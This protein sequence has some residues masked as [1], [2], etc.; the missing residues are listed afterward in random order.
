MLKRYGNL[1]AFDEGLVSFAPTQT[2]VVSILDIR[3][4]ST[5]LY[6]S[7]SI[8]KGVDFDSGGIIY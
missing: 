4:S 3:K 2:K 5:D 1:Q 8:N 7:V 6:A